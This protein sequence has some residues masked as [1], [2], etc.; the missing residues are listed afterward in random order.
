MKPDIAEMRENPRFVEELGTWEGW[1]W[2]LKCAHKTHRLRID[3][4]SLKDIF[5][6]E[7]EPG[8]FIRLKN[9]RDLDKRLTQGWEFACIQRWLENYKAEFVRK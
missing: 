7:Y 5:Y 8:D 6:I 1:L 9:D 2:P 4:R 3:H